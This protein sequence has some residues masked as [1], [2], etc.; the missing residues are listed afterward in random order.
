VPL[1]LRAAA[2]GVDLLLITGS[3]ATSR[4]VFSTLRRAARDGLLDH[5]GLEQS[6][7]RIQL[8]KQRIGD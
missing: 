6:Y 7:R 8:L 5:R 2:A 3:E 4:A 1:A